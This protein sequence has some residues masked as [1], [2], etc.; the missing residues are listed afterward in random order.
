MNLCYLDTETTGLD[1]TR[2]RVIELSLEVCSPWPEMATLLDFTTKIRLSQADEAA[3]SSEALAVNGY[4][5]AAWAEGVESNVGFWARVHGVLSG[6]VLVCQNVAFDSGFI[7]AE[8]GRYKLKP[9]WD[10]RH[11]ELYS[12]THLIAE[13]LDVRD[14][15]GRRTW[16]LQK[17]YA[18]LAARMGWPA[19]EEHRAR[20]DREQ[21]KR[22]YRYVRERWALHV[23]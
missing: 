7:A 17:V 14:A 5:R 12:Y 1:P 18:A 19:Q 23:Q 10:R 2:H 3:A 21:V 22:I 13:E 11:V 6:V 16:N 9:P 15:S 8:L 20:G 4:T